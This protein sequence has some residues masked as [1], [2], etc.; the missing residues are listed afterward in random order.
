MAMPFSVKIALL[1]LII[2][3]LIWFVVCALAYYYLFFFLVFF[4]FQTMGFMKVFELEQPNN[5]WGKPLSAQ[6]LTNNCMKESYRQRRLQTHTQLIAGYDCLKVVEKWDFRSQW[7]CNNK[8]LN[9]VCVCDFL[10]FQTEYNKN[11][12][13]TVNVHDYISIL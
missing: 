10:F 13:K 12:N 1:S 9:C 7:L 6:S 8:R 4:L 11:V 2:S 5:L 3:S